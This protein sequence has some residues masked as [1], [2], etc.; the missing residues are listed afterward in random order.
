MQTVKPS[1]LIQEQRLRIQIDCSQPQLTDQSYKNSCDINNIMTQYA[2]TG[3]LPNITSKTPQFVDNTLIPDLNTAFELVNSA[4][5]GFNQLP[6]TI[7]RLMDN[8]P[9]NLESFISNRDNAE[10]LVKHGI[11]IPKENLDSTDK[12]EPTSTGDLK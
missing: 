12:Q 8:N 1:N 7:R 5:E 11:L 10:I 9:A 6:P 2:K 4:I 3:M